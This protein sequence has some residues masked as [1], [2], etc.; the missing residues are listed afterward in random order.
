[1]QKEK[2]TRIDRLAARDAVFVV[3]R[4]AVRCGDKVLHARLSRTDGFLAE[5]APLALEE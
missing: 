5:E 3:F 1:M 2:A 4:A